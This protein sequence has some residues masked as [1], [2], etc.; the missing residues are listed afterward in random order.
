M[1][2]TSA[3]ARAALAATSIEFREQSSV[4]VLTDLLE[5]HEGQIAMLGQQLRR[6]RRPGPIEGRHPLRFV[7]TQRPTT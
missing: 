1:T 7:S 2:Q 5:T 4:E 6:R 3:D